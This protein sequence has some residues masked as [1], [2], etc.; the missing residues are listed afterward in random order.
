MTD[1]LFDNPDALL[2]AD[3]L[4]AIRDATLPGKPT[5][6]E[7]A[8]A[9]EQRLRLLQRDGYV[10]VIGANGMTVFRG[11]DQWGAA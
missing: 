2:A 8:E 10:A 4:I 6:K 1:A 9:Q 11:P 3:T 5:R 7:R